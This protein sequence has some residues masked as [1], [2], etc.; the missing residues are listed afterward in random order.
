[1][2]TG[3]VIS[4]LLGVIVVFHSYRREIGE[5][6]IQ[7]GEQ[8]AGT[9]TQSQTET[10]VS[11]PQTAMPTAQTVSPTMPVKSQEPAP[12]AVSQREKSPQPETNR[13]VAE[14]E[15]PEPRIPDTV[16][17]VD[18]SV[19][20]VPLSVNTAVTTQ[21]VIPPSIAS[22]IDA[23]PV[24][25]RPGPEPVKASSSEI[26]TATQPSENSTSEKYLEVARFKDHL[27]ATKVTDQLAQLGFDT[28]VVQK[29][30]LWTS[31][32][33]VLVGP[34]GD[35]VGAE[36]AHESLL[37][38]GFKPRAFERGSRTVALRSGLTLNGGRIDIGDCVISW[39]SY[40]TDTSVKFTQGEYVVAT[41]DGQWVKRGVRYTRDE[42][43]Y[44]RNGDGSKTL[45]EMRF[46]GMNQALVFNNPI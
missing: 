36:A 45:L 4:A 22:T 44:R 20:N 21:Q 16:L 13:T 24:T 19:P 12:T 10:A 5:S 2:L 7:M 18:R 30:H 14:R 29:G 38:R 46:S 42:Y 25:G 1:L 33:R 15:S 17:N 27:W 40:M 11:P 8:F 3:I 41:A 37:S 43:V 31:S 9:R 34:Y 23:P 35:D 6:L 39:E 28:T 32:Y 26:V